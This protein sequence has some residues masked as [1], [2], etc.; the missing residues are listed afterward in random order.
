M[1]KAILPALQFRELF[2]QMQRVSQKVMLMHPHMFWEILPMLQC[3]RWKEKQDLW[4]FA[5]R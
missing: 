4:S 5:R 2:T 3:S 1:R